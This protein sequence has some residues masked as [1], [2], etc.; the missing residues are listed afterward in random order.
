MNC[1]SREPAQGDRGER[2]GKIENAASQGAEAGLAQ[3]FPVAAVVDRERG[4]NG[5]TVGE[6]PPRPPETRQE[7][8]GCRG[9]R[10]ARGDAAHEEQEPDHPR[11]HRDPDRAGQQGEGGD[12]PGG[13]SRAGGRSPITTETARRAANSGSANKT[14]CTTRTGIARA[15]ARTIAGAIQRGTAGPRRSVRTACHATRPA[16]AAASDRFKIFAAITAAPRGRSPNRGVR[17]S[18]YSGGK[19]VAAGAPGKCR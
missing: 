5:P 9:E 1:S 15:A 10:P 12:D 4:V 16:A 11:P 13:D 2:P 8:R 3:H 14:D 18:G 7:D 6:R 17:I 19:W